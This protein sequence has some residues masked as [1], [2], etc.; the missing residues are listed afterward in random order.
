MDHPSGAP[1]CARTS[2]STGCIRWR[3]NAD[4]ITGLNFNGD[5]RKNRFIEVPRSS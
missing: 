2:L 3:E 1:R 5:A 4:V